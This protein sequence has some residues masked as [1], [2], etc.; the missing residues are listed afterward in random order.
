MVIF[1]V[2]TASKDNSIGNASGWGSGGLSL[3]P[4]WS[5]LVFARWSRLFICWCILHWLSTNNMVLKCSI[6][7]AVGHKSKMGSI[8]AKFCAE[9]LAHNTSSFACE[10][11]LLRGCKKLSSNFVVAFKYKVWAIHKTFTTSDD[12]AIIK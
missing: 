9:I 7:I 12:M 8:K 10:N 5:K 2:K 3:N 6:F 1:L 4:A 11:F